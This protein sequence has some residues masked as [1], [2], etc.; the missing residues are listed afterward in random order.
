MCTWNICIFLFF[1]LDV[2]ISIK[3]NFSILSFGITVALLIFCLE[4]LSIDFNE[5]LKASTIIVFPSVSPPCLLISA[6]CIRCYFI[7]SIYVNE[8]D[9]HLLYWSFIILQCSF[10]FFLCGLYFKVHFC[11][12]FCKLFLL[13]ISIYEIYFYPF[14][15]F[16]SVSPSF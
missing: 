6:L 5:G 14:P 2:D 13:V 11:L 8:C 12:I 9:I 7:G 15:Y 3:S 10:L 16:Q 1:F 4:D